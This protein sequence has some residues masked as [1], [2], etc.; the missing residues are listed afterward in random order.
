MLQPHARPSEFSS[1]LIQLVGQANREYSMGSSAQSTIENQLRICNSEV[2]FLP[3]II[4]K[5]FTQDEIFYVQQL[6][7]DTAPVLILHY[8]AKAIK[9]CNGI[10]GSAASRYSRSSIVIASSTSSDSKCLGEIQFFAKC[11]L[12]N[13]RSKTTEI[14]YVAAIKFFAQHE[15]KVWFGHPVE[16]WSK[17]FEPGSRVQFI[18]IS[19]IKCRVVYT[20]ITWNFGRYYG[21][22]TVRVIIPIEHLSE[23]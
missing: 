1:G 15:C 16:V 10:V 19:N 2:L 18:P 5:G 14:K 6:F 9:H 4:E 21:S 12:Y 11:T 13:E 23:S 3:P 17:C 7:N 22:Q 8:R 20:D